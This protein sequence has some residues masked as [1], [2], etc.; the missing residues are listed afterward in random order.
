MFDYS[1][2]HLLA[3]N[4]STKTVKILR[5]RTTWSSL[6]SIAYWRRPPICRTHSILTTATRSRS[7]LDSLWSGS[8]SY[9]FAS[10][11]NVFLL[12]MKNVKIVF[13]SLSKW[14][15]FHLGTD[16]CWSSNQYSIFLLTDEQKNARPVWPNFFVKLRKTCMIQREVKIIGS[17]GRSNLDPIN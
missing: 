8:L 7:R 17:L 13:N 16:N 9:R 5:L 2:K 15:L 4:V 12:R 10:F 1:I 14:D 6:N 11:F 3:A